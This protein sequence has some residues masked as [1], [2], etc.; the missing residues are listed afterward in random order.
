MSSQA[1]SLPSGTVAMPVA[2]SRCAPHA[3]EAGDDQQGDDHQIVVEQG[4]QAPQQTG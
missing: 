1:A 3:D 2:S 4:S